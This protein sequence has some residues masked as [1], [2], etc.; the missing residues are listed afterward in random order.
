[1]GFSGLGFR[2]L[3]LHLLMNSHVTH[4][5]ARLRMTDRRFAELTP[6]RQTHA[7]AIATYSA[8][9]HS[10][11]K[12]ANGASANDGAEAIEVFEQLLART[13]RAWVCAGVRVRVRALLCGRVRVCVC[14]EGCG[15]FWATTASAEEF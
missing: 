4:T 14:A 11:A 5:I 6:G 3:R 7:G 13:A 15:R 2:F 10:I 1:L 12:G 9:K 8:R